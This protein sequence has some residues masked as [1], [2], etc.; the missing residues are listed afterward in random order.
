MY[1]ALHRMHSMIVFDSRLSHSQPSKSDFQKFW[2]WGDLQSFNY[3]FIDAC[4]TLV[5]AQPEGLNVI[6]LGNISD[7]NVHVS[8]PT[9]RHST[10]KHF[11]GL[12][13]RSNKHKNPKTFARFLNSLFSSEI[14]PI[15]TT[16]PDLF[17][18]DDLIHPCQT[19]VSTMY[20][21]N[22]NIPILD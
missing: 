18:H 8:L 5:D 3:M 12:H 17:I 13:V 20:V 11:L 22:T 6:K 16:T 4:W 2:S 21:S 19:T 7:K 15:C 10:F 9:H 14:K 1:C